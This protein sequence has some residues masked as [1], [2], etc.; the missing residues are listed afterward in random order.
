MI[1]VGT[2]TD[3]M[4]R[5]HHYPCQ[6]KVTNYTRQK[7]N[8]PLRTVQLCGRPQ[9][10]GQFSLNHCKGMSGTAA[11]RVEIVLKIIGHE[12]RWGQ[13]VKSQEISVFIMLI[14]WL[15]SRNWNHL[16]R[17]NCTQTLI[18]CKFFH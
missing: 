5:Y 11:P 17:L 7:R 15:S 6:A 16:S 12:Q 18:L 13:I 14:C 9:V 1:I 4:Q 3:F 10:I 2:G 8:A